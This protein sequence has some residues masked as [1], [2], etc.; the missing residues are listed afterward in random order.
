MYSTSIAS[1]TCP[2]ECIISPTS[3]SSVPYLRDLYNFPTSCLDPKSSKS[4]WS[5]P[6]PLLPATSCQSSCCYWFYLISLTF[7]VLVEFISI[8]LHVHYHCL[9]LPSFLINYYSSL[10]TGLPASRLAPFQPFLHTATCVVLQKRNLIIP[11]LSLKPLSTELN[12]K[13]YEWHI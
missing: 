9:G 12:L 3:S 8:L 7:L 5:L 13:T 6:F 2:I 11:F 4:P 1:S 10:Q